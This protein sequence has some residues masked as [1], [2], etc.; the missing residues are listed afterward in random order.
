MPNR[1]SIDLSWLPGMLQ[2][3]DTANQDVSV[4]DEYPRTAGTLNETAMRDASGRAIDDNGNL[5]VEE[6][7]KAGSGKKVARANNQAK[8]SKL[9]AQKFNLERAGVEADTKLRTDE[10]LRE[11]AARD[12]IEAAKALDSAKRQFNIA[13]GLPPDTQLTDEQRNALTTTFAAEQAKLQS[14]YGAGIAKNKA[15]VPQYGERAALTTRDLR[16]K[17]AAAELVPTGSGG[18][19]NPQ[20][21][22]D[23]QTGR[24][25]RTPHQRTI[26]LNGQEFPVGP[27]SYIQDYTPGQS[28]ILP[29]SDMVREFRMS[30]DPNAG[31][32]FISTDMP[33]TMPRTAPSLQR[34]PSLSPPPSQSQGAPTNDYG[35]RP[36]AGGKS[37][38]MAPMPN[39]PIGIGNQSFQD[40]I[41]SGDIPVVYWLKRLLG[42]AQQAAAIG[43]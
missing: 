5:I 7:P 30:L 6:Q 34:D 26:N 33:P 38:S 28:R 9:A 3:I 14:D 11:Q 4:Q 15:E 40:Q 27:I 36:A 29:S 8:S 10:A 21:R 17:A 2:Q 1:H 13:H 23:I 43:H 12:P 39:A 41:N 25:E 22:E 42:G 24:M 20:T 35:V 31:G 16:A 32:G 18:L 37:T 19:F